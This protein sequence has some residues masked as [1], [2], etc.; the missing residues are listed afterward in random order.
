MMDRTLIAMERFAPELDPEDARLCI[1][2]LVGQ[3]LHALKGH[4]L[5]TQHERSQIMKTDLASYIP[6]F[7]RF[8]AGGIRAC[9]E[10]TASQ[11]ESEA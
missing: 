4:H 7:V 2:S 11:R 3:L 9:A 10:R 6:H 5:F 8:S 1:L